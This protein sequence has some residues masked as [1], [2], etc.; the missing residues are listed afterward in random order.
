MFASKDV[1]L[2]PPTGGYT[3]GKSVRLRSSASAYLNRT[4]GTPTDNKKWTMSMWLKRGSLGG[5]INIFGSVI[6]GGYFEFRFNTS[7]QIYIQNRVSS[8]NLLVA[9]TAAV[10]RDP[11]AWYHIVFAFDSANATASNRNLLYVNGVNVAISANS[12]SGDACAFNSSGNTQY[13]GNSDTYTT[14][15]GYLTEIN[16]IDGQALTPSSFGSTNSITG[17]WQPA[18]YTGTY[19]TNGFYLNFSSNGTSAALGTDFSGNSN[20][21][22]VNNISVTA[23]S[24]YD[25]MTD[26]PTLTSAT[27]AN[28][29]VLN[30]LDKDSSATVSDGNLTVSRASGAYSAVRASFMLPT[31]GKFYAEA[32]VGT[33]TASGTSLSFGFATDTAILNNAAATGQYIL[34]G[35]GSGSCAIYSSGTSLG[36]I[37]GVFSAGDIL[38]IAFDGATGKAWV[39]KNNVWYNATAGTTGDPANGTNNTFSLSGLNIFPVAVLLNDTLYFNAGQRPFTYT[40]PTGFVAL[41]TYNLPTS[42]IT[43][44]AGYM[45]A[46]T[47]TGNGSTQTIN[48]SSN[49]VSF[50]PDFVWVKNRTNANNH[51]LADAVRG[52]GLYLASS[53]TDAEQSAANSITAFNSN[54][55][56]IGSISGGNANGSA[57]V[58]WQWKAGG[59]SASNTNGSITSTVSAGALQG[60]SVVTYTGNGTNGATVGHGLGVAPSMIIEKGRT[61]TYNWS[62]QGCGKLWTPATSNLFL[63][64]TGALNASGAIAAPTSSVFTPSAVAYA[65][66]SGV[67]NIAY[68]FAAVAGYSAFGSYT[69]NG[70]ADGTFVYTGFRPRFVMVKRTDTTGD[71]IVED[72]GRNTY[73]LTNFYLLPN[74]STSEGVGDSTNVVFDFLSNGFKLRG[75]AA[76]GN[77]SGGTYIYA[78]FA[79]NPFKNA[80]A[81]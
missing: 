56:S 67:S 12:G 43:N 50:Q 53:N 62:V 33:T 30:P 51:I 24:T 8:T 81:R 57:V 3:I 52:T 6:T 28:Y 17:V 29:C 74:S 54:G 72:S 35:A 23:G 34:Y 55:F 76:N 4:F 78:C 42:T 75:T 63:N 2:T 70:S 31:S 18:K 80:L 46:T 71:W 14:F 68:C 5:S 25:S 60:F 19:G 15:D 45:A 61:S 58:G 13:I 69:G 47:Y 1:F 66:E 38:Q 26:V 48:N 22:T 73:N 10:Y 36:S 9:N 77:A 20:T 79:E 41:N 39:G 44:G 11:S 49:G 37:S 64:T 32:T 40:P 59:T 7:D 27:A 16:F 21:W 65:N